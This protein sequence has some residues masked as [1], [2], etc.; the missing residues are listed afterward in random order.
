MQPHFQCAKRIFPSKW[1]VAQFAQLSGLGA[2][3]LRKTLPAC[4]FIFGMGPLQFLG[5]VLFY[6]S[7]QLYF[8]TEI[9]WFYS[10]NAAY[11]IPTVK[12]FLDTFQITFQV[13]FRLHFS[14]CPEMCFHLNQFRQQGMGGGGCIKYLERASK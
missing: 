2:T 12:G 4:K 3:S 14:F 13:G 1:P 6:C 5:E 8:I 9:N 7:T 10:R 11:L